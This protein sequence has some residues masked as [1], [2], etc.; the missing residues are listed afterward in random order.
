MDG[1]PDRPEGITGAHGNCYVF[2]VRLGRVPARPMHEP[3][4]E[5]EEEEPWI[6]THGDEGTLG[7]VLVT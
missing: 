4:E 6:H 3:G 1:Q 7:R 2:W 5:G